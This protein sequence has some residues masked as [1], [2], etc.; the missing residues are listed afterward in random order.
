M[1]AWL[2][3]TISVLYKLG[4]YYLQMIKFLKGDSP[5]MNVILRGAIEN[6]VH[7]AQNS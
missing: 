6:V 3:I 2:N 5:K 4:V 7:T 1:R